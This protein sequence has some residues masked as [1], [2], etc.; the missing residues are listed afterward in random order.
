MTNTPNFYARL[1]RAAVLFLTASLLIPAFGCS[2]R[3]S[4]EEQEAEESRRE[5]E[6]RRPPETEPPETVPLIYPP[7]TTPEETTPIVP[8]PEEIPEEPIPQTGMLWW[9]V[10]V[11]GAGGLACVGIGSLLCRKKDGEDDDE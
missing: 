10:P 3:M 1:K 2:L 9:P 4:T 6:A 5:E 7:E 8:P 11:M